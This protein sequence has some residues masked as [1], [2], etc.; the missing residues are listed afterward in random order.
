MRAHMGIVSPDDNSRDAVIQ[1]RIVAAREFVEIHTNRAL[2]T[3]TWTVIGESTGYPIPVIGPLQSS[4]ANVTDVAGS[5]ISDAPGLVEID[6]VCG[7]GD[8]AASVPQGILEAIMF[9]VSQ[10]E[11]FQGSIEG[12]IRPMTIPNAAK[13][14]LNHYID[15]RD[16]RRA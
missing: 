10:W 1:S 9:M 11:V 3:Q 15:Y 2:I 14:L 6:Y 16:I 8:T 7:Y 12:I 5:T 4:D 13:E